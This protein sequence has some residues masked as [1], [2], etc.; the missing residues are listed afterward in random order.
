M[1]H[2]TGA[3]VEELFRQ[4]EDEPF[5][6]RLVTQTHRA[7]LNSGTPAAV[8]VVRP[9]VEEQLMP[10]VDLLP[11]LEGAMAG[12]GIRREALANAIGNFAESLQRQFDLAS[13]ARWL[14]ALAADAESFHL[15]YGPVIYPRGSTAKLLTV[16]WPS[17]PGMMSVSPAQQEDYARALCVAWLR[18]A[19][20]GSGFPAELSLTS[21]RFSYDGRVSFGSPLVDRLPKKIQTL[22]LDYLL[23]EFNQDADR[24]CALLVDVL[25]EGGAEEPGERLLLEF[26][27]AV[28][29]RHG[30]TSDL[31]GRISMHWWI[32]SS[33][34]C[35]PRGQLLSFYRSLYA[36]AGIAAKVAPGR[37][38]LAEAVQD[39]HVMA[40]VARFRNM[41][42]PDQMAAGMARYACLIM[43]AP[44]TLDDGLTAIHSG[45]ARLKL[46]I[47]ETPVQ[48]TK[49]DSLAVSIALFLALPATGV[50]VHQMVSR[51]FLGWADRVDAVLL[52]LFGA[53]LLRSI[54]RAI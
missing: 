34:G 13:E 38:L 54:G 35:L 11:L 3:F 37:D 51:V 28:P 40:G 8:K 43:D 48:R 1:T 21:L 50:V 29:Y 18:Q 32:A 49:R 46:Q 30:G 5:E 41:I 15:L 16:D 9:D 2:E 27:Q 14:D 52:L 42:D 26:R 25:R 6:C 22:L 20:L 23:A 44:R 7:V 17:G 10:D 47:A 4:F 33:Q 36:V 12:I 31:A 19:L 24:A 45:H 53:W 39:V